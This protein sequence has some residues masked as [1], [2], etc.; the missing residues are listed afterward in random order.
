MEDWSSHKVAARWSCGHYTWLDNDRRHMNDEMRRIHFD[1]HVPHMP[2]NKRMCKDG[3]L[4]KNIN[5]EN[6]LRRA[7]PSLPCER[8]YVESRGGN[9]WKTEKCAKPEITDF[10]IR[11][12]SDTC[13]RRGCAAYGARCKDAIDITM[14]KSQNPHCLFGNLTKRH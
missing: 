6:E 12:T 11:P 1:D 3:C 8:A 5:K 4:S 2:S 13:H 14:L 9:S 10:Y 7:L